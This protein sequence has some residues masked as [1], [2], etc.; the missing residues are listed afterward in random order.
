MPGARADL[1]ELRAFITRHNSRRVAN[2]YLR[3][4]KKSYEGLALAPFRGEPRLG[5]G[6]GM[7]VVGFERRVSIIFVVFEEERIVEIVGFHYGGR[8]A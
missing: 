2:N 1:K 5:Y 7:R 3:R 6:P 4:L 8:S